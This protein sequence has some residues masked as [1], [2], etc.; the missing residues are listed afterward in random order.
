MAKDFRFGTERAIS[1]SEEK[2]TL[3]SAASYQT[4]LQLVCSTGVEI[5]EPLLFKCETQRRPSH[6]VFQSYSLHITEV[7]FVTIV[8]T[9]DGVNFLLVV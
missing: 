9:G 7:R 1:E 4:W 6:N 3:E 2:A 8:T 5:T